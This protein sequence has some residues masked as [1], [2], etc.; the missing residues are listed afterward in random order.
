MRLSHCKG[1]VK[2]KKHL[3]TPAEFAKIAYRRL[4]ISGKFKAKSQQVYG[5]ETFS[6]V[7]LWLFLSQI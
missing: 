1:C 3:E 2:H 5:G 4:H 6:Y 7:L